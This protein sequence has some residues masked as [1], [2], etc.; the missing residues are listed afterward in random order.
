[1]GYHLIALLWSFRLCN[2]KSTLLMFLM[3]L[4]TNIKFYIACHICSEMSVYT[5]SSCTSLSFFISHSFLVNPCTH[6]PLV[7]TVA[8]LLSYCCLCNE[9]L[10]CL[11]EPGHCPSYPGQT[12]LYCFLQSM[13][14]SLLHIQLSMVGLLKS[15]PD[16]DRQTDELHKS[17]RGIEISGDS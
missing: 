3:V 5:P 15:K 10:C 4:S 14:N 1:M 9:C 13:H 8:S 7:V 16:Q 6:H 12:T 17:Q 11:K 2:K